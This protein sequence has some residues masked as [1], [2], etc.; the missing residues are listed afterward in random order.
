MSNYSPQRFRFQ[1]FGPELWKQ[2]P[3]QITYAYEKPVLGRSVL[4]MKIHTG[5]RHQR[6]TS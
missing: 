6:R 2:Q 5:Q 4:R 1:E 3:L